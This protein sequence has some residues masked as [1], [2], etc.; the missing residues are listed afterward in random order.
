RGLAARVRCEALTVRDGLHR[1]IA[2]RWLLRDLAEMV[3]LSPKQLVRVFAIAYGKTPCAYLGRLQVEAMA[4]LLREE[5]LTVD[6]AA[7]RVGWSRNQAAE[8][9][10]RH[11]GTTPGRCRLYGPPST[12]V[13]SGAHLPGETRPLRPEK[14]QR[15]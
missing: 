10:A 4:R 8:M 9:F 6:A 7:H 11:V 12:V 3:H 13:G 1:K 14:R 2:H 15:S 5:N